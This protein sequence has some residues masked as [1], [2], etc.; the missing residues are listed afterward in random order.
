[1]INTASCLRKVSE[2]DLMEEKVV[3][4]SEV[5]DPEELIAEGEF[6]YRK[7]RYADSLRVLIMLLV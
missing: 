6:L 4:S 5:E 2:S 7:G 1:M 3:E